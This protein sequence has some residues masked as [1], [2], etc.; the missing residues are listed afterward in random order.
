M[1]TVGGGSEGITTCYAFGVWAFRAR[2]E[3]IS[4]SGTRD[5]T[6]DEQVVSADGHG[7]KH[8]GTTRH[9]CSD[10]KL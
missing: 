6:G 9:S 7:R 10:I 2:K 1:G 4:G 5:G 3:L 8:L